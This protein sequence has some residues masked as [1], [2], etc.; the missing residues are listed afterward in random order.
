MTR[1]K[2]DQALYC[3]RAKKYGG[4]APTT[5]QLDVQGSNRLQH[6]G[7]REQLASQEQKARESSSWLAGSL[8]GPTM[9]QDEAQPTEVCLWVKSGKFLDFTISKRGIEANP[10]KVEAIMNMPHAKHQWGAKG[11]RASGRLFG[12]SLIYRTSTS[13]G[14]HKTGLSN[15]TK[16]SVNWRNIWLT[17]HSSAKQNW[18]KT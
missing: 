7:I 10:E 6:G 1:R 2:Q 13:C 3:Y 5:S 18:G 12:S 4:N 15:E 8:R 11:G 9:V 17:P 16:L 14:R